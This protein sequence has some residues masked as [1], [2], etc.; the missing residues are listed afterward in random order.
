MV[1]LQSP[2]VITE[3]RFCLDH[4][5]TLILK[6]KILTL[7]GDDFNIKD[8]NDVSYFKCKGKAFS[9]NDKKVLYDLNDEPILNISHKVFSASGKKT[10]Y[11]GSN[12]TERLLSI[13]NENIFSKTKQTVTYKDLTTNKFE[14][15]EMKCDFFGFDCSI[16]K[17]RQKNGG[18]LLCRIHKKVDSKIFTSSEN[19]VVEIQPNVDIAAMVALAIVFDEIKND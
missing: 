2:V 7:S 15:I 4:P 13:V 9:F 1:N 14:T 5:V 6:E 8:T 11:R 3:K 18:P 19:Y 16:Y 12:D 17:G 10:V